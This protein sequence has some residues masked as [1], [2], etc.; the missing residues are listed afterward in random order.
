MKKMG[1]NTRGRVMVEAAIPTH[2]AVHAGGGEPGVALEIP[3]GVLHICVR[4]GL[5]KIAMLIDDGL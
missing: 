1:G 5:L 4:A 2:S 3:E